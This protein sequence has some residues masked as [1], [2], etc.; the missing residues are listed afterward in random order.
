MRLLLRANAHR[1]VDGGVEVA[2]SPDTP[3]R[4]DP[5]AWQIRLHHTSPA[6]PASDGGASVALGAGGRWHSLR[7]DTDPALVRPELQVL[8]L[9][10][11]TEV[12]RDEAD[13]VALV[14]TDGSALVEDRHALATGDAMV[15]TGDDPLAVRTTAPGGEVVLVRLRPVSD[16]EVGWVP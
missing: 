13:L 4:P 5:W 8:R 16:V 7:V 9:E 1:A 11:T 15:F 6:S 12:R 3:T 10:G 14:V 2:A